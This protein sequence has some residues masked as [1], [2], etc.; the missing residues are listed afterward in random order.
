MTQLGLEQEVTDRAVRDRTIALFRERRIALPTL[1]QL[2]DPSTI[3]GD[4]LAALESVGPDAP[5]PLNLFRVHW[6]LGPD[7]RQ[8]VPVPGNV[9]LPPEFTGVPSPILVAYGDCES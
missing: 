8:Q 1:S 9:V 6:H 4:M 7:R 5:D 2:A 3:D